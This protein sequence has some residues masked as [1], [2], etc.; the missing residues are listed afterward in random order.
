MSILAV[1]HDNAIVWN[2][3][4]STNFCHRD[5]QVAKQCLVVALLAIYQRVQREC[6]C[7]ENK[8]Q[9]GT[10]FTRRKHNNSLVLVYDVLGCL[11]ALDN[12]VKGW[13]AQLFKRH[14][15][16]LS[17]V[18]LLKLLTV[19]WLGS[20]FAHS[21]YWVCLAK[22]REDQ[23]CVFV[24]SLQLLW[25]SAAQGKRLNLDL[26]Q[27][28]HVRLV[29][30]QLRKVGNRAN[31]LPQHHLR[32][33]TDTLVCTINIVAHTFVNLKR[34]WSWRVPHSLC[35]F[36]SNQL[37]VTQTLVVD[38]VGEKLVEVEVMFDEKPDVAWLELASF[39]AKNLRLGPDIRIKWPW[40]VDRTPGIPLKAAYTHL[41]CVH[42]ITIML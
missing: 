15:G 4:L 5:H 3:L 39:V 10:G 2:V 13:V 8:V 37:L 35:D 36:L 11:L 26:E 34:N 21:K 12:L 38:S 9:L 7:Q 40:R 24:E 16:L 6:L 31:I 23:I 27:K 41:E 20:P 29:L 33:L 42:S 22:L 30:N 14:F 17:M 28:R 1:V 32:A 19:L 25:E 18:L